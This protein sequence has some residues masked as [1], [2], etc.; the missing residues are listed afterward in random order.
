M[1]VDLRSAYRPTTGPRRGYRVPHAR[2]A[3]GVGA[4]YTPRTAV[5]IP[6]D[7]GS[8]P[9]PAAW[10][11]PVPAPGIRPINRVSLTEASTRV[12]AIHPSGLPLACGH[13]V[14]TGSPWA[15]RPGLRTPPTRSRTAHARM[16]T[17]H[18]ARTWNYRSTHIRCSPIRQ[19]T[20]YVRPRVA[21]HVSSHADE[22]DGT[23]ASVSRG[24]D[25][26]RSFRET[27]SSVADAGR[28]W[29]VTGGGS[30]RLGPPCL[31]AAGR[32]TA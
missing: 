24:V 8:R 23:I 16:G 12:Q 9:A 2:A 28:G 7:R 20:Q 11:R 18:R 5:L 15:L 29:D 25:A 14:G 10:Q 26:G 4:L 13:P 6:T 3:T 17:G 19:F 1:R 21:C 32:E 27:R 30:R 31:V 22:V